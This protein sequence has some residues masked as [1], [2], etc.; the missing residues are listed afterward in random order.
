MIELY[1]IGK[2]NID[3]KYVYSHPQAIE[4]ATEYIRN[5]NLIPIQSSST[6][7]AVRIVKEKYNNNIFDSYAIANRKAAEIYNLDII[8]KIETINNYTRFLLIGKEK[9]IDKGNRTIIIFNVENKPGSLYK[10]LEYFAKKNINLSKIESIPIK[11]GKWEYLF[12]VEYEGDKEIIDK[13]EINGKIL[14]IDDYYL[15]I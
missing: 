10:F 1:L 13:K 3:G 7:E 6:S 5:K 4:Q 12:I 14:Y 9:I 8:E 15:K 2:R 11:N